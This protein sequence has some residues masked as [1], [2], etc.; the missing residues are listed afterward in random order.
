[1]VLYKIQKKFSLF[2]EMRTGWDTRL[3]VL[4]KVWTSWRS[5]L[6]LSL[7]VWAVLLAQKT[8]FS[9][10]SCTYLGLR[11]LLHLF[12]S[13]HNGCERVSFIASCKGGLSVLSGLTCQVNFNEFLK[14]NEPHP[15][16]DSLGCWI[17][18][19]ALSRLA[20]I[21][22]FTQNFLFERFVGNWH[23]K[24]EN[25]DTACLYIITNWAKKTDHST[26]LE[27]MKSSATSSHNYSSYSTFCNFATNTNNIAKRLILE[28]ISAGPRNTLEKKRHFAWVPCKVPGRGRAARGG[29]QRTQIERPGT[30]LNPGLFWSRT[31]DNQPLRW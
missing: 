29:W 30:V 9:A 4:L 12:F 3:S 5:T 23:I 10:H 28:L 19:S 25:L 17:S 21:N 22:S 16:E 6:S 27:Q 13:W 2:F 8:A 20:E 24:A 14:D 7:A 31:E 11:E 18:T 15:S 1:M 26:T